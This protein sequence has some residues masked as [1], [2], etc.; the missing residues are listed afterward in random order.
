[1]ATAIVSGRIDASV[2]EKAGA[3][4]KAA[5]LTPADIIKRVWES[6]ADTGY[7]PDDAQEKKHTSEAVERLKRA[8]DD[9]ESHRLP[10][11]SSDWLVSLTKEDIREIVTEGLIEKYA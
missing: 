10:G 7:I 11:T 6:I 5:G 9:L 1:M 2:K 8:C 4:I 3:Y